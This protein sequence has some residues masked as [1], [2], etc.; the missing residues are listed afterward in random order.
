MKKFHPDELIEGCR[1]G[2]PL[3]QS[4]LFR[5]YAPRLLP[6]CYRYAGCR[7]TADDLLQDSFIK[8]FINIHSFRGEG[9]FEGWL[10]T[11]AIN[12]C[13]TWVK[14]NNKMRMV[15]ISV[16][17][18]HFIETDDDE[19][20]WPVTP[21]ELTEAIA[22]LPEGYRVVLNMFAIEGFSHKEIGDKLN[23]SESTSRSQYARAKL[24]LGK[25]IKSK[26]VK[27]QAD[28]TPPQF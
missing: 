12:T 25:K 20:L 4:E 9:N 14:K 11:I 26:N 22:S 28:E 13:I 6:I 15:D 23:I 24:W 21:D 5:Q 10:K 8:I 7:D 27:Y 19:W 1:K 18:K 16:E 17:H 2:N 3:A